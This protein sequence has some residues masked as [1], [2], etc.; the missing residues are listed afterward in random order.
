MYNLLLG[1]SKRILE[2]LWLENGL[3]SRTDVEAIQT[4]VNNFVIP[5]GVGRISH[6][7]SSKFDSLTADEWKN[8]AL[9]FPLFVW[10][11]YCRQMTSNVGIFLYQLAR[12]IFIN[13]IDMAYSL[14]KRFFITAESLYGPKF[15]TLNAHIHLH[16]QKCYKDYGPCYG[17]WLFSFELYNGMLGKFHTMYLLNCS[18]CKNL[19]KTWLLQACREILESEHGYVFTKFLSSKISGTSSETKFKIAHRLVMIMK[20]QK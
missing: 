15:L 8:W 10:M 20:T 16:L 18:W 3:L 1:T 6:K 7:I 13:D 14:M 4:R 19:M 12:L 9:L 11:I 5:H 17:F 2:K